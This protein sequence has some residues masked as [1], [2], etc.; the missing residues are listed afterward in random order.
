MTMFYSL[1][2][3]AEKQIK[4]FSWSSSSKL[5]YITAFFYPENN[6][7]FIALRMY[8]YTHLYAHAQ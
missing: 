6:V 4:N 7:K 8:L 2:K 1:V 5:Y 3:I